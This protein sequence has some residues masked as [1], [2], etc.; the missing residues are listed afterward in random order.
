MDRNVELFLQAEK[1]YRLFDLPFA[2]EN[3]WDYVRLETFRLIERQLLRSNLVPVP[4]RQ[5]FFDDGIC[6]SDAQKEA[7][8]NHLIDSLKGC[9]V[10]I[11]NNKHRFVMLDGKQFCPITGMIESIL[12]T[13]I[14]YCT[15]VYDRGSFR[16]YDSDND[17]NYNRIRKTPRLLFAEEELDAYVL[18]L[19]TIFDSVYAISLE[20]PFYR[21]VKAQVRYVA[22]IMGYMDF[23]RRVLIQVRPKCLILSSYYATVDSLMIAEAKQ[24]GIATIEVQH[25]TIGNEHVAYNCLEQRYD[26]PGMPD[27]LAAYGLFDREVP[28]NFVPPHRVILTGNLFLEHIRRRLDLDNPAK[29]GNKTNKTVLIVSFNMKNEPL[30]NF[31]VELKEKCPDWK[32]IYRFHPEEKIIDKNRRWMLDAG[33]QCQDD[34]RVSIYNLIAES[35]YVVGTKSTVLYESMCFGKP[36]YILRTESHERDWREAERHMQHVDDAESF[37]RTIRSVDSGT[38]FRRRSAYFYQT[39]GADNFRALVDRIMEGDKT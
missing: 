9:Q 29:N 7:Y 21:D 36:S 16:C 15:Q 31:A 30:V 6:Y 28:R 20:E 25:G 24:L 11:V 23:Y 8:E 3:L 17:I 1:Q 32:V 5:V 22:D 14:G 27:Y 13:Q 12:D 38:E 19:G 26:R 4:Y 34:F 10:L 33:V 35:D 37:L 18:K 39:G 2:G